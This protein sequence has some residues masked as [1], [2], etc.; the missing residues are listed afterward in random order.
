MFSTRG[1]LCVTYV[2]HALVSLF[3]LGFLAACADGGG[4]SVAGEQMLV[5]G[6]VGDG[7]VINAELTFSDA[8]G[9]VVGTT[10]SDAFAKYEFQVPAGTALP[11]RIRA[12]GGMD[13]VTG[14]A[15]DFDLEASADVAGTSNVNLNPQGT[16]LMATA[17]CADATP[18]SKTMNKLWQ[19][20]RTQLAMGMDA[21]A[22]AH[23]VTTPVEVH[24]V[25]DMLLANEALGEAIRRAVAQLS[26]AD[27]D[28]DGNQLVARLGCD[29]AE[30]NQINGT[31]SSGSSREGM[32]F[33]VVETAVLLEVIAGDL[34]VDDASS[35]GLLDQAART[36]SDVADVPSV[37][38][39]DVNDVLVERTLD[40]VLMLQEAPDS[41]VALLEIVDRLNEVGVDQ[42]RATVRSLMNSRIASALDDLGTQL[43]MLDASNLVDFAQTVRAQAGAKAPYISLTVEDSELEVGDF[44]QISWATSAANRCIAS[45]PADWAGNVALSGTYET[46]RLRESQ[47]YVL[48]CYSIGGKNRSVATVLVDGEA[49]SGPP[50]QES[51]VQDDEEDQVVGA[52]GDSGPGDAGDPGDSGEPGDSGAPGRGGDAPDARIAQFSAQPASIESGGFVV[53]NWAAE[54]VESCTAGQGWQGVLDSQGEAEVGPLTQTTTFTLNCSGGGAAANSTISVTVTENNGTLPIAWQPPTTNADNTPVNPLAGYRI[55]YGTEPGEY[56]GETFIDNPQATSVVLS[57]PRGSYYVAMTAV[58]ANGEESGLSNEVVLTSS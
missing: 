51:P 46:E 17:R 43:T 2:R 47:E 38:D 52:P 12:T 26:A 4:S 23:P 24:N 32:V 39:V 5:T 9:N 29:L 11:L 50:P 14:R 25:D 56:N 21:T 44:T 35:M 36:I 8:N 54:N 1:T 16:L 15:L 34:Q 3:L 19:R 27:P 45:G 58:S 20:L 18:S 48:D 10:F 57:L 41:D 53:L 22:V 7:P 42:A 6:S 33:R 37:M 49:V 40:N 30:D 55:L 31:T 13:L 28:I